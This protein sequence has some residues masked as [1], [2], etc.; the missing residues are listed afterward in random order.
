MLILETLQGVGELPGVGGK[1][2]AYGPGRPSNSQLEGVAGEVQRGQDIGELNVKISE[3][4]ICREG[5]IGETGV[6]V[7]LSA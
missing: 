3:V 4:G 7:G 2:L 1:V 5:S 6:P